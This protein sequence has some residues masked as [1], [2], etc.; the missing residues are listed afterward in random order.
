MNHLLAD[1]FPELND[2]SAFSTEYPK[3][4][5]SSRL[6]SFL[7][8]NEFPF[9]Y[10]S[11]GVTQAL[12]E[13]HAWIA[14]SARR[15]RLLRGEY[16]YNRD[17]QS[18]WSDSQYLD[19]QPLVRGDAVIVSVPFSGTGGL[20]PR[21]PELLK[22]CASLEI[23][24]FVDAAFFGTC[25]KIHIDLS[26]PTIHGVAFST[27]KGLGCGN[28]R[29]GL[30]FSRVQLGHL[31]LQ[32]EWRHGIHL[33]VQIS[34]FLM[35]RYSPD[36]IYET[37]RAAQEAVCT[38]LGLTPSDSVHLGTGDQNWN[39]FT[40]DGVVNRIGLAKAIRDFHRKGKVPEFLRQAVEGDSLTQSRSR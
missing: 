40:R 7:G 5:L 19:D 26:H 20:H 35:R 11:L 6:N 14:Q 38:H 31:H 37:Y 21:W 10:V 12:D 32:N 34:L 28:W 18:I 16:P 33:N 3:W 15:L 17:S 39:S 1:G 36:F 27:T 25:A 8:L 13:W 4:I 29:A 24:I 23:P 9:R 22:T 30:T 2:P